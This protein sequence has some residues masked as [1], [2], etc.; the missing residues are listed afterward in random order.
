M[1]SCTCMKPKLGKVQPNKQPLLVAQ[2]R[3]RNRGLPVGIGIDHGQW[4]DALALIGIIGPLC[5]GFGMF[6]VVRFLLGIPLARF[7][8]VWCGRWCR[9]LDR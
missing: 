2:W 7:Q 5:F 3:A 4:L 1:T 9:M 6:Q 8:F